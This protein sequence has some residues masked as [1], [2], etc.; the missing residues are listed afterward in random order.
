MYLRSLLK[1]REKPER[2]IRTR[3][4]MVKDAFAERKLLLTRGSDR[5]KTIIMRISGVEYAIAG[6]EK[7]DL[8]ILNRL[9]VFGMRP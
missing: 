5:T 1:K 4:S 2:E 3:I 8:Y 9:Y 7:K 6:C